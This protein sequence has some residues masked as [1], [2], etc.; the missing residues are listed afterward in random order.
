MWLVN[1]DDK[2]N[3]II[4]LHILHVTLTSDSDAIERNDKPRMRLIGGRVI[5]QL[6]MRSFNL[7][8]KRPKP[9]FQRPQSLQVKIKDKDETKTII[10]I[11]TYLFL[12][13][14]IYVE[15][16]YKVAPTVPISHQIAPAT[17]PPGFLPPPAPPAS[18]IHPLGIHHQGGYLES[19]AL[20]PTTR[21]PVIIPALGNPPPPPPPPV[22]QADWLSSVD[23]KMKPIFI[24]N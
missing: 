4:L 16:N 12:K 19:H 13:E 22:P 21:P 11:C 7:R 3:I 23:T 2:M 1:S 9:K 18:Y 10:H 6:E 5:R 24:H 15:S 14:M 20:A 8:R 17:R